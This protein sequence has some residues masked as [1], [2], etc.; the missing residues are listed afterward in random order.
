[1]L[2]FGDE[3]F[4]HHMFKVLMAPE[5]A[6]GFEAVQKL[7]KSRKCLLQINIVSKEPDPIHIFYP[8]LLRIY[9]P[10]MHIKD[11]NILP[12]QDRPDTISKKTARN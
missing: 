1:M 5:K 8:G 3:V 12:P 9:F 2:S 11:V 4:S 7:Q 6:T 10:W